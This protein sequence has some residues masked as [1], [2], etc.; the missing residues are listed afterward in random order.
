MLWRFVPV[1]NIIIIVTMFFSY[2]ISIPLLSVPTQSHNLWSDG[3]TDGFRMSCMGRY[4]KRSGAWSLNRQYN[5]QNRSHWKKNQYGTLVC[6]TSYTRS[7][8]RPKG[9][10]GGGLDCTHQLVLNNEVPICWVGYKKNMT[11][12]LPKVHRSNRGHAVQ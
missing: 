7:Q 5:L 11:A 10:T 8:I 1:H 12:Y 2:L 9:L 3:G 6:Y 4:I